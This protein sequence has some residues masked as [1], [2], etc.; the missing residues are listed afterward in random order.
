MISVDHLLVM[1]VASGT[2]YV[3]ALMVIG[4]FPAPLA[5]VSLSHFRFWSSLAT[6]LADATC[7]DP[8]SPVGPPR[9]LLCC[10]VA[11]PYDRP[12]DCN[13]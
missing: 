12:R 4:H 10:W 13:I 5:L 7:T 2:P 6:S 8:V 1:F 3:R 11:G 9:L